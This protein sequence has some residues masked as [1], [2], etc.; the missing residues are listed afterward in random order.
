MR[1][2]AA[3]KTIKQHSISS[4]AFISD[5]EV[6]MVVKRV[7][8]WIEREWIE[9]VSR[10][11]LTTFPV[12]R[13][14]GCWLLGTRRVLMWWVHAV[15]VRAMKVRAEG[16][17]SLTGSRRYVASD[18][19]TLAALGI[20]IMTETMMMVVRESRYRLLVAIVVI[21]MIIPWID[22]MMVAIC[23]TLT[24]AIHVLWNSLENRFNL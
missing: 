23:C 22:V 14:L 5:G 7:C 3:S 24:D 11:Q 21:Y 10:G 15:D 1:V 12:W 2:G 8:L 17:T 9:L 6:R 16:N 18:R 19:S 4:E 13:R 20:V